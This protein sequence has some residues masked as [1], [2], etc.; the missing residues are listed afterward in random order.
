MHSLVKQIKILILI[1]FSP[2]LIFA[3]GNDSTVVKNITALSFTDITSSAL[4]SAPSAG[5]HCAAFT[6]ITGDGLPDLYMTMYYTADISDMFYVNSALTVFSEDASAR[7]INDYDGGSHGAVFADLDNDGDFD[8]INGTTVKRS[9]T[10]IIGA[11]HNNIFR[12]DG[13]GSFTDITSTI[14]DIYST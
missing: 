9:G 8:L 13:S 5:S 14:S 7:G 10:T 1:V 2:L 11:D 12:N 4:P 6:D 3:S